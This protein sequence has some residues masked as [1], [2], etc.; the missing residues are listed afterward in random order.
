M[1]LLQVPVEIPT[2]T[3]LS[4]RFQPGCGSQ[5]SPFLPQSV[6]GHICH[7][8]RVQLEPRVKSDTL[9]LKDSRVQMPPV[10]VSPQ[11]CD[12][13]HAVHPLRAIVCSPYLYS[14]RKLLLS[15]HLKGT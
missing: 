8:H 9:D 11:L 12:L 4:D 10:F 13:E 5:V 2:K 15:D 14:G 7:C 6:F 3:P 1:F